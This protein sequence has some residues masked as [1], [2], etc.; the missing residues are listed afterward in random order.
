MDEMK[1]VSAISTQP[2]ETL[3]VV[4]SLTGQDAVNVAQASPA[5]SI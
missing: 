5:R 1:A 2:Q 3:L 4:D